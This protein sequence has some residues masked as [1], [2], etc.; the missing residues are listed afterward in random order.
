MLTTNSHEPRFEF[1]ASSPEVLICKIDSH[2]LYVPSR[3]ARRIKVN[4]EKW[5][6][7][8]FLHTIVHTDSLNFPLC[9]K[10]VESPDL[11]LESDKK[12]SVPICIEIVE[13]IPRNCAKL[14]VEQG[15]EGTTAPHSIPEFKVSD[16]KC[17]FG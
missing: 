13:M 6:T 8:Q 3:G 17:E 10:L 14:Q 12:E 4:T 15:R 1:E 9:G 11:V 2:D 5:I 7:F 16:T